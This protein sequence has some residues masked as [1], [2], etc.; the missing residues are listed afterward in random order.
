MRMDACRGADGVPAL[1]DGVRSTGFGR[2]GH[3]YDAE[4]AQHARLPGAL[5]HGVDVLGER[6]VGEMSVRVDHGAT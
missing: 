1:R 6:L 4:D 2:F 3:V 5:D